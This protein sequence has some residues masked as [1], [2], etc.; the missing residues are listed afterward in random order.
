MLLLLF[1]CHLFK[2][3]LELR[4]YWGI[5]RGSWNFGLLDTQVINL[6]A[7]LIEVLHGISEGCESS[8]FLLLLSLLSFSFCTTTIFS[9]LIVRVKVFI[10]VEVGVFEAPT[11]L[12]SIC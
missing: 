2:Y 12:S 8:F 7:I 6:R 4:I 10:H 1:I 11:T 5:L 3:V 9:I